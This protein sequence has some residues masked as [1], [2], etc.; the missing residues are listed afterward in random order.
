MAYSIYFNILVFIL[1]VL[2]LAFSINIEVGPLAF[3]DILKAFILGVI[4]GGPL[5]I[6]TFLKTIRLSL[7]LACLLVVMSGFYGDMILEKWF[8]TFL[9]GCIGHII[10]FVYLFK[11]KI[12]MRKK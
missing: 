3:R 6:S 10:G 1:G 12:L 2:Y 4:F 9:I 11:F 8:F 5:L 7:G